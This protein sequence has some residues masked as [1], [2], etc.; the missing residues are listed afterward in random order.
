VINE[1]TLIAFMTNKLK[2]RLKDFRYKEQKTHL[3]IQQDKILGQK[4]E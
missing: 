1:S 4:Q 2:V 3:S